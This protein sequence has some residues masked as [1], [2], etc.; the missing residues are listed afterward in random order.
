MIRFLL[1]RLGSSVLLLAV[2][3]TLT[4]ALVFA[5]GANVARTILGDY[6]STEQVAR[7]AAELGIDR[8]LVEQ[9][10]DWLSRA[11][12]G[13]LGRSW[14]TSEPV[15]TA[16]TSRFSVTFTIVVIVVLLSAVL[17][18]SLGVLAAVRGGWVDRAVQ[19]FAIGGYALPGYIV[20]LILV[21]FLAVQWRLFPATGFVQFSTDPGRWAASLVL[22]VTAL[23]IST[24][25][26][27][28]QQIRSSV[29]GV[30]HRDFVRTLRARGLGNREILFRHVLR[31][32]SPPGLTIIAL[33][34]VGLLGGTVIVEQIF[35]IP[36]IGFLAVQST[37]RSDLPIVLGVVLVTVLMVIVVNLLI[38]LAIAWLNPRVRLT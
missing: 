8:P 34:F 22:P 32:A 14:F 7:K 21:T 36:G 33:Q 3:M 6:A 27:S 38:D 31:S 18:I 30:L 2:V 13:D 5:G 26:A 28:A 19:V 9:Y 16:I 23:V 24:V 20:A 4:F 25:A 12:T 1:V 11:V 29:L 37:T 15:L 10:L 35:A 17:S